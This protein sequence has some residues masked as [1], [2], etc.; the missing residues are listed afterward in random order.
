MLGVLNEAYSFF[1]E[2]LFGTT[3]L[4][5]L[6]PYAETISILMAIFVVTVCVWFT[7][8]LVT[9]IIRIVYNFFER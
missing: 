1:Y 2:W 9:S 8:K 6:T 3:P 4:A 7:F 5:A